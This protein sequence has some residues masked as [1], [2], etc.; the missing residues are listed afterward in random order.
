MNIAVASGKGGTGKTTV[1]VN[2]ALSLERVQLIDCDVE[3]PN[4]HIFVKP[5][6][7]EAEDVKTLVPEVDESKCTY[8][9]RCAEF[10]RYNALAVVEGIFM[11][12]PTLCHSCGGCVKVC[13]EN[14][15]TESKRRVGE[16]I[17]SEK[18][19]VDL[20]YGVL[21]I[22]EAMATPVIKKLKKEARDDVATVFDAPPGT[23]CAVI[24]AVRGCDF[25]I[26]VTEPTPFGL[27]DLKLAVEMLKTLGIPCG[28]VINRDGMGDEGV[29]RYCKSEKVEILMRIPHDIRIARLYSEGIPFTQQMPEY[30][31]MFKDMYDKI[32][33]ICGRSSR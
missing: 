17:R 27:N 21:D 31:R 14:A 25:C 22:G 5:E 16:I 2:L 12:F 23:S 9:G 8:C 15:L 1:A 29:E 24:E 13:P 20:L 28:V 19:G 11:E 4:C 7:F 10:C 32:E 3:E 30:K 33:A 26:L 18:D 6:E